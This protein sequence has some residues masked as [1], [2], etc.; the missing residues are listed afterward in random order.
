MAIEQIPL[1]KQPEFDDIGHIPPHDR[2]LLLNCAAVHRALQSGR[3]A[4]S[5]SR[6]QISAPNPGAPADR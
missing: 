3:D 4:V 2:A 6:G 1:D 5:P